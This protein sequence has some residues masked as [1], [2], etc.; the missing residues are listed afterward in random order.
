MQDAGADKAPKPTKPHGK[1]TDKDKKATN[2]L[3]SLQV[4]TRPRMQN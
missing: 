2:E 1:K 4:L 3:V